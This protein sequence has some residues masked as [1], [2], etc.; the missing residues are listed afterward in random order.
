MLE[1]PQIEDK[2]KNHLHLVLEYNLKLIFKFECDL[3][4]GWGD[5]EKIVKGDKGEKQTNKQK[6][7]RLP[8]LPGLRT[9]LWVLV[10]AKNSVTT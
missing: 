3:L 1:Y 4:G 9:L 5:E 10:E 8:L 6:Q 2:C 7:C